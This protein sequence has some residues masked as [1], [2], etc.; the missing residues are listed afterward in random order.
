[1]TDRGERGDPVGAVRTPACRQEV[2]GID[3]VTEQAP[4]MALF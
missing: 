3:T 1:M 4:R 2:K